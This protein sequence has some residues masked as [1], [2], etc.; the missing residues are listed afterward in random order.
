M[1]VARDKNGSLYLYEGKPTKYL[2]QWKAN[3]DLI[4]LNNF[5]FPDVKWEDEEPLE[6]N[7][8]PRT[9]QSEKHKESKCI[10]WEQRKYELAKESIT[11]I[12]S[13][14]EFYE[15]VL[16]EGREKGNR[17]ITDN[18]AMAAV[19]IADAVIKELRKGE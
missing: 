3:G 9:N 15:Q 8:A 6:V 12:M 1:W 4:Q 5:S 10:D 7:I 2:N 16:D 19:I 14:T 18:V 11:A 13:N 17:S